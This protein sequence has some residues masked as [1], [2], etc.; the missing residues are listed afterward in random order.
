VRF[1]R[2]NDGFP[3]NRIVQSVSAR[4]TP[5]EVKF[6]ECGTRIDELK[7]LVGLHGRVTGNCPR[8]YLGDF[9][10]QMPNARCRRNAAKHPGFA[11]SAI[12]AQ[13]TT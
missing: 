13:P 2:G 12:L 5:I 10:G 11:I 7:Q 6:V 8:T 3:S 4:I 9:R 1:E